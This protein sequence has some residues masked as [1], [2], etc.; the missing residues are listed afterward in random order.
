MRTYRAIRKVATGEVFWK[1]VE[2]T[3]P[4]HYKMSRQ[5]ISDMNLNNS[6]IINISPD[7][8]ISEIR[9]IVKAEFQQIIS[10]QQDELLISPE[11]TRRLFDPNISRGTLHN[12]TKDGHLIVHKLGGKNYYKKGEVL[13][14]A[15][16]L[17]RFQT[18]PIC[19]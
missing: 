1:Y 3:N 4:I 17:K 19:K 9:S 13:A 15:K 6:I 16:V 10:N 14:A 18:K 2:I 11:Q 7:D 5:I 8:L 12:W